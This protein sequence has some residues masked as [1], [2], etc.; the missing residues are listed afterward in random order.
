MAFSCCVPALNLHLYS[1]AILCFSDRRISG[2]YRPVKGK[3]VAS[4][5][6]FGMTT[7]C[8]SYILGKGLLI[9]LVS[10]FLKIS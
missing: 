2:I 8:I 3:K 1:N 9:S 10:L 5:F 7:L 4:H 6:Q